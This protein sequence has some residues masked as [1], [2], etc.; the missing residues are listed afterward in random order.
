MNEMKSGI[1]TRNGSE[2]EFNYYTELSNRKKIEFVKSVVDSIVEDDYYFEFLK[3][4]I[5]DFQIINCFTDVDTK[6]VTNFDYMNDEF[7]ESSFV[8]D[9]I[10]KFVDETDIADI[11]KAYLGNDVIKEL[12]RCI[13]DNITYKTGIN[14]NS[15]SG[16][17]MNLIGTIDKQ[18]SSIDVTN[19]SSLADAFSKLDGD[20]NA[21]NL[22]K[23]YANSD[24]FKKHSKEIVSKLDERTQNMKLIGSDGSIMPPM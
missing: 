21:E 2:F 10:E 12:E 3:Y 8:I 22:L 18:L 16:S 4:L 19:L 5:F 23:A 17:I 13:D 7:G 14:H 11:V 20:I 9:R 24:I 15:I 6:E 1:Y